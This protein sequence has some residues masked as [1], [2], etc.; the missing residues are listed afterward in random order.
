[1]E[2]IYHKQAISHMDISERAQCLLSYN[3]DIGRKL[4]KIVDRLISSSCFVLACTVVHTL[5]H[6]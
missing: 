2:A 3:S 5:E 6:S 4:F 1:M